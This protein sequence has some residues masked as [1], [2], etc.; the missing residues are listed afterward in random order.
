MSVCYNLAE[1]SS[2]LSPR[3]QAHFYQMS[4]S[5]LNELLCQI[6]ISV[7]LKYINDKTNEELREEIAQLSV[8]VNNLHKSRSP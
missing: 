8:Y 4:Y 1:G 6:M 7:E 5:S 3:D 2:R